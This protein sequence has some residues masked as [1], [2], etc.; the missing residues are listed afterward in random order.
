M[1]IN[2][3]SVKEFSQLIRS[4]LDNVSNSL[5]RTNRQASYNDCL[6]NQDRK[7]RRSDAFNYSERS[8]RHLKTAQPKPKESSGS[9][10]GNI[11]A[12]K[13]V[14][15]SANAPNGASPK[16]ALL[17]SPSLPL[18]RDKSEKPERNTLT[19]TQVKSEQKQ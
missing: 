15:Q 4:A 11:F 6:G 8:E 5:G 16:R 12:F 9:I 7:S 2:S 13:S 1:F 19:L 18:R 17:S 3:T 14:T 10:F